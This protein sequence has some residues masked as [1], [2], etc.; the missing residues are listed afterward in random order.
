MLGA[1]AKSVS[2]MNLVSS[3]T[4]NIEF[5]IENLNKLK[6]IAVRCKELDVALDDAGDALDAAIAELNALVLKVYYS[7]NNHS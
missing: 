4:E 7:S 3:S 2:V 5:A 6:D 1:H